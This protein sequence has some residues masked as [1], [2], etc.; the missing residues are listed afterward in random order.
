MINR[1]FILS[2]PDDEIFA[3]PLL[4]QPG[5][6]FLCYL[7]ISPTSSKDEYS[8]KRWDELTKSIDFLHKRGICVRLL[9]IGLDLKD[10]LSFKDSKYEDVK[11]LLNHVHSLDID[12]VY[13]FHLDGGHQDH[14]TASLFALLLSRKLFRPLFTFPGYTGIS[15]RF[16]FFT[17]QRTINPTHQVMYSRI[18]IWTLTFA[19]A[20]IHRTQWRSLAILTPI[21]MWKTLSDKYFIRKEVADDTF[22]NYSQIPLYQLRKKASMFEVMNELRRLHRESKGDSFE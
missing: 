2:H 21:I 8:R 7:T 19:L 4:T 12:E 10:S 17:V 1:L 18:H 13:G 3:L 14:D 5:M 16:P 20:F 15:A 9:D 11:S 6:N 22:I